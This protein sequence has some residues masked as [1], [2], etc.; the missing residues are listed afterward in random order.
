[1]CCLG[2]LWH[3]VSHSFGNKSWKC[4]G[5]YKTKDLRYHCMGPTN[6]ANASKLVGEEVYSGYCNWGISWE[7]SLRCVTTRGSPPLLSLR[8]DLLLE[9][10]PVD[11]SKRTTTLP[12]LNN[13]LPNLSNF[14]GP[15]GFDDLSFI[16][17]S[18]IDGINMYKSTTVFSKCQRRSAGTG[19]DGRANEKLR[20]SNEYQTISLLV[21]SG[22][23]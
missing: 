15:S 1:M 20:R 14:A 3:G 5:G 17:W 11:R 21:Q 16:N 8:P 22:G 4:G 13:F 9:D 19:R 7:F 18:L 10:G 6:E 2:L 12:R 23:R